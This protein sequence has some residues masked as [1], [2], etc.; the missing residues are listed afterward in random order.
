MK[1]QISIIL[2]VS[3]LLVGLGVF[4]GS[5]DKVGLCLVDETYYDTTCMTKYVEKIG[6]PLLFFSFSIFI[7]VLIL[8]FVRESTYLAWRKFAMWA[9]PIGAIILFLVPGSSGGGLGISGPDLTK[10][11]AS[12]GV[13]IIFLIISLFIIIKNSLS[14]ETTK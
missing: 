9:V 12:W 10:E 13:S 5:A 11:T 6:Q 4:F 2:I 8:F 1:K 7:S 14:G 3:I